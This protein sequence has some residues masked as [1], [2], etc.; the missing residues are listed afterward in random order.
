[1]N[2]N[3]NVLEFSQNIMYINPSKIFLKEHIFREIQLGLKAQPSPLATRRKSNAL[4]SRTVG[5]GKCSF[6][7]YSTC[8]A[9][10][11]T[12]I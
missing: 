7:G 10:L 1:M 9:N 4:H 3:S 2:Y 8:L 11:T 5:T 6:F 12:H